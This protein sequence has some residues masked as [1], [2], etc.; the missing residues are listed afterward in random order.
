VV[1]TSSSYIVLSTVALVAS[2]LT[3]FSGFGLGTILTP[4]FA[5]FFSVEVAIASTAVV[6][7]SNNLFKLGMLW[8]NADFGIVVRFAVPGAFT[9]VLGAMLLTSLSNMPVLVSYALAGK[10]FKVEAVK[11]VVGGLIGV[12]AFLELMPSLEGR[13]R[14]SR[15]HLG[16]AGALSGFF[17]GLSG[18]QGALRSAALIRCGL[19]KSAFVATGVVC[20][21]VVDMFRLMGY[22]AAFYTKNFKTVLDAGGAGLVGATTLAA[23]VGAFAGA[24]LIKKVTMEVVRWI[25][26][27]SLLLLALGLVVGLI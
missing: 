4:I 15:K 25:V 22:G 11:L 3:L 24:R 26:G 27:V 8:R 14:F 9:A 5:V 16:I 2:G 6:H 17:G 23:F 1:P 12:F 19:E 20:A 7:L 21:V 10:T 18:N 13:I